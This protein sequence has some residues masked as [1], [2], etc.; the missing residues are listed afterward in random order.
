MF[1]VVQASGRT[2]I[3]RAL[4]AIRL[5]IS[6]HDDVDI[7]YDAVHLGD[8]VG[9][10]LVVDATMHEANI[11]RSGSLPFRWT[12]ILKS[13]LE[14]VSLYRSQDIKRFTVDLEVPLVARLNSTRF[15]LLV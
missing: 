12:F 8:R 4:S 2:D 13:N 1:T 15:H 9:T 10:M 6:S 7:K 11:G 14:C 5:N 3:L